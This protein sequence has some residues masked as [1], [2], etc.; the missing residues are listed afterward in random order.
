MSKSID[1]VTLSGGCDGFSFRYSAKENRLEIRE[2]G[3]HRVLDTTGYRINSASCSS[4]TGK[5]V[6]TLSGPEG[7]VVWEDLPTGH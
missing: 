5:A 3:Q 7:V 6:L 1:Q 2:N 4:S